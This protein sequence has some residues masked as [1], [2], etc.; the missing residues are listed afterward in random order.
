MMDSNERLLIVDDDEMFC[1][2]MQRALTRRGYEV[3]VAHDAETA[4]ALVRQTPPDLATL[5]LKLEHS[6]GLKLLPE[7][8]A[9]APD[10]RVIVLTGYSSIAT[11]VEAI[12]LGAVNYLCKPVDADEI[13]T[14][15][16]RDSGD[17]DIDIADNPPSI[18]RVTWEHIQKIL[19]EHDGN[20]SATAR[21]L[22][23]HRRTLQRKLQKRPV[24]R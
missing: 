19:Q 12:K 1:H 20:I 23:M 14:A 4:L 15:L 6:S 16:D 3:N 21:A 22:G 8:L 7:L 18:N 10:C 11:A 9:I 13:V 24:R 2:V 5:D 17:P